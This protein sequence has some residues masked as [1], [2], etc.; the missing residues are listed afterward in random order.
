MVELAFSNSDFDREGNLTINDY[1][2]I[3]EKITSITC[4]NC[5]HPLNTDIIKSWDFV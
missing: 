2:I 4:E 3:D 1:D 5:G